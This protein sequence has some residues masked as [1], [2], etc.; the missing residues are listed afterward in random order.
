MNFSSN[1]LASM[2]RYLGRRVVDTIYPPQ[3][4]A[5]HGVVEVHGQLCGNCWSQANFIRSPLCTCCGSPFEFDQGA[6]A[7]CFVCLTRRPR[8]AKARAA[9]A[10]D[11]IARQLVLSFKHGDRLDPGVSFA[12]MMLRAGDALAAEADVIAPVPLHW[13]RLFARR[14]N[15]S[16]IL[17]GHVA[18]LSGRVFVPDLLLRN[19]RTKSQAFMKRADRLRNVRRAFEVN[20]TCME[21]LKGQNVLLIDDV[22]TTGATVENCADSLYKA[23][24]DTVN[25]LTLARVLIPS[26]DMS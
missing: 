4:A 19:R 6:G 25:V 23:G 2:S 15:Q 14:Y 10:Y 21:S 22:L 9:L 5:C 7:I 17:A 11:D 8:F 26:K 12:R 20:P 18:A 13:T 1:D 3:C 24:A 16:A